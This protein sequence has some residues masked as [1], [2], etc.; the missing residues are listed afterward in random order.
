M[1]MP[2]DDEFTSYNLEQNFTSADFGNGWQY[3]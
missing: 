1:S 3:Q 2:N